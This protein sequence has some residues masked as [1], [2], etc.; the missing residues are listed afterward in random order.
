MFKPFIAIA[1]LVAGGA[2]VAAIVHMQNSSYTS[3][4][5][6]GALRPSTEEARR[7]VLRVN[8]TAPTVVDKQ[9]EA[10]ALPVKP[11]IVPKRASKRMVAPA[12]TEK[13]V[14]MPCSDWSEIG[15]KAVEGPAGAEPRQVRILC[16][17]QQ[18]PV[19]R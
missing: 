7:V 13:P 5:D 17:N 1:S 19:G 4:Y 9:R 16:P 14:Y 12:R 10:A 3:V 8:P 18:L 11:V 15:I 2:T 6:E